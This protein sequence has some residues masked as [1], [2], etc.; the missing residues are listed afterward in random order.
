MTPGIVEEIFSDTGEQTLQWCYLHQGLSFPASDPAGLEH[1]VI[2]KSGDVDIRVEDEGA[3][4]ARKDLRLIMR[5]GQTK[6]L[7]LRYFRHDDA[8]RQEDIT[9]D[10]SWSIDNSNLAG[11]SGA[12]LS[13]KVPESGDG[14]QSLVLTVPASSP[15]ATV[16]KRQLLLSV[17]DDDQY[18]P[19][20]TF[21]VSFSENSA[22]ISRILQPS[23]TFT[24]PEDDLPEVTKNTL[25]NSNPNEGDTV[26]LL[27]SFDQ[28]LPWQGSL[29]FSLPESGNQNSDPRVRLMKKNPQT[30]VHEPTEDRNTTIT[31]DAGENSYNQPIIFIKRSSEIRFLGSSFFT[32]N[33]LSLLFRTLPGASFSSIDSLIRA[34]ILFNISAG[35][36]KSFCDALDLQNPNAGDSGCRDLRIVGPTSSI[37]WSVNTEGTGPAQTEALKIMIDGPNSPDSVAGYTCMRWEVE[38]PVRIS[39]DWRV[40][41]PLDKDVDFM[42]YYD[43]FDSLQGKD[44]LY[45]SPPDDVF[46]GHPGDIHGS[47]DPDV[48]WAYSW[49]I[50]DRGKRYSSTNTWT[51]SEDLPMITDYP[52][53]GRMKAY[54]CLS[55]AGGV[56]DSSIQETTATG[57]VNNLRAV[58]LT[59]SARFIKPP[60]VKDPH[61]GTAFN[62]DH[63]VLVVREG[64]EERITFEIGDPL[65]AF[66]EAPSTQNF[67]RWLR[68]I[69]FRPSN[70]ID[71]D[72]IEIRI[73]TDLSRIADDYLA[74][75]KPL[76]VDLAI[77]A[78]ND[79]AI[80]TVPEAFFVIPYLN[81]RSE[82]RGTLPRLSAVIVDSTPNPE[83]CSALNIKENGMTAEC[84]YAFSATLDSLGPWQAVNTGDIRTQSGLKSHDY[85]AKSCMLIPHSIR[86]PV[87]VLFG[88][89]LRTSASEDDEI[90]RFSANRGLIPGLSSEEVYSSSSISHYEGI[91][92]FA[93]GFSDLALQWCL[94]QKD[95]DQTTDVN[96]GYVHNLGLDYQIPSITLLP[97]G[98][99]SMERGETAARELRIENLKSTIT[100]LSIK[101]DFIESPGRASSRLFSITP[102]TLPSIYPA[103]LSTFLI[104][105]NAMD[106]PVL[107]KETRYGL[108]IELSERELMKTS[109]AVAP[110]KHPYTYAIT[111]LAELERRLHFEVSTGR[112]IEGTTRRFSI[113]SRVKET[114]RVNVTVD[115]NHR[116]QIAV[117]EGMH[118]ASKDKLSLEVP[119]RSSIAFYVAAKQDSEAEPAAEYKIYLEK[120]SPA[121]AYELSTSV[122][123]IT[124]ERSDGPAVSA[125]PDMAAIAPGSSTSIKV[126]LTSPPLDE[127]SIFIRVL[128]RDRQLVI[129]SS[130]ASV[131]TAGGFEAADLEFSRQEN[132]LTKEFSVAVK[133]DN[134]SQ[135]SREAVLT[136]QCTIGEAA[137]PCHESDAADLRTTQIVIIITGSEPTSLRL[138]FEMSTG[139]LIEGTTRRFSIISRV[140]ETTR[141]NVTVDMNHRDQIAVA[142]GMHSAS[143]DKLSLEVP[144]R[145]S[146]AFY[147]AAKQDSEAEPAAEYKIY[148]EKPSPAYAYELSTSVLTITVERSDGP[149]VSADPDM[150]AI[151]PGSSTSIKVMLTSPPLDED[152]IF[153]RVLARDRQLVIRSSPASVVT[154]GGFEAADLEFSRQENVLTKEFSVAVKDDNPS[155]GSREAVL[156]LQCTIGEA[157]EPC[158]ES[159]AAD[160][161]TARIVIT[162]TGSEPSSLRL[163]L[164]VYLEGAL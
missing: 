122:L 73:L 48:E 131:V 89:N 142:E 117:A 1:M 13:P 33:E 160:L 34:P 136:L 137:E 47:R 22:A 96:Q 113:I 92:A 114:T 141:V 35:V 97:A 78:N 17:T 42:R 64:E 84:R 125:D 18:N 27:L 50:D 46:G 65:L 52:G 25:S 11:T 69:Q 83:F 111:V 32:G 119:A 49:K 152:S 99:F 123:T 148:L 156:T 14:T 51:S 88:W 82:Y 45:S 85:L 26:N 127:D 53:S 130:P 121:Y 43:S 74:Q 77:K 31:I 15:A 38:R 101:A 61:F 90:L 93:P 94:E 103:E 41:Q 23:L 95:L 155:Q 20:K 157:A 98:D 75:E 3:L 105:F 128:A 109:A 124:V 132:V 87:R 19:T 62:P 79:N 30:G 154:A 145:S 140:K 76:E 44:R 144:A 162:I 107:E 164:K 4:L 37:T 40:K 5:E 129:R 106:T 149:A 70:H 71:E 115:M 2:L 10:V 138:H 116:D 36:P 146:I 110:A 147:V 153:I 12:V 81:P 39:F 86:R 59:P 63:P 29:V 16:V 133:D 161:R 104:T 150:A 135:G 100:S 72:E 9:A 120:P 143:K 159:D 8:P 108:S 21:T 163:R 60:P 102:E 24:V 67:G 151:A 112:L 54:W 66:K 139:R 56:R 7:L 58:P 28:P 126:M 118:S 55:R 57:F 68:Q 91:Y 134:P 158:H 6:E 80:E